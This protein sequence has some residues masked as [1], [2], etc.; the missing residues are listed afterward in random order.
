[1]IEVVIPDTGPLISLARI[2]R[3]DLI[4]RFRSQILITDA[5]EIELMDGPQDIPD[6]M[7]LKNWIARGG[8]RVRIVETSYG[9]LLRQNRELLQFVPE[10][11][12]ARFRRRGKAKDAGENAIRELS[13][14][15][16]NR[17][18]HDST[19]LVLFEDARVRRMD[20]GS[21]VRLMTTWSF[22]MALE[23]LE[24][25]PS[26]VELFDRI[27]EA[28]RTPPRDPFDRRSADGIED[29]TESYDFSRI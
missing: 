13:D 8:N 21:H 7:V 2:G 20:F 5:V 15:I 23:Q 1:M 3:L 28:G 6:L 11:K 9:A 12:R 29:F 27:E 24:V 10:E 25:I 14:E 18:S 26:A 22:A 19:V 16:R 17:L 4:D